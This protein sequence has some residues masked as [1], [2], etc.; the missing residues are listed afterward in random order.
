MRGSS[1]GIG[2]LALIEAIRGAL[3]VR[4]ERV[5]RWIGDDCA[6]IRAGGACAVS[7][8]V[9]VDGTHFR[10]GQASPED[11]GWRALAGALSDIAAMGGEAGEA[12]L[13]VVLPPSMDDDDVLALHRGA[14]ALA[15]ECGVTIAGGDLA[16]GPALMVAVTVMGWADAPED[17]VRRDTARP[18]DRVGVTGTLGASAAGLA[19]LDGLAEGPPALVER[20]LRPWPR[21]KEGRALAGKATAMMDLSDGIASD[22]RRLAEASGVKLILDAGALPHAPGV[23]SI[24]LAATGGEDYELLVCGPDSLP[25]LTWIGEVVEGEG[26]EWV[27]APPDADAWRG[28]EH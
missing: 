8:D 6:V 17:F 5:V 23:D 21:L 19:I 9:M 10:L 24:Q 16:R 11:V 3:T 4:S 1:T 7:T 13:S 22:A 15:S 26:V 14:E 20:Y 28:F 2:E 18:G 27:G 12:Y 25:L